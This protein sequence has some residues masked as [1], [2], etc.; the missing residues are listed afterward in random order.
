MTFNPL[1]PGG[2]C[3]AYEKPVFL[4]TSGL[5]GLMGFGVLEMFVLLII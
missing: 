4:S 2:T 1:S 3:M 5:Q